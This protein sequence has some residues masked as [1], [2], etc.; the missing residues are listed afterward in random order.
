[1][2][3]RCRLWKGGSLGTEGMLDGEKKITGKLGEI[4]GAFREGFKTGKTG[5][6]MGN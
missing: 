3:S 6:S 5:Y 1:M 2:Q 4:V